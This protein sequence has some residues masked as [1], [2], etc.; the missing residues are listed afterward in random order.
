[1]R[2]GKRLLL[3]ICV[4]ALIPVR[5]AAAAPRSFS[6]FGV[7]SHPLWS[8]RGEADVERELDAMAAAGVRWNRFDV[9]WVSFEPRKGEFSSWWFARLDRVVKACLDRGIE[10]QFVIISTPGWA[11]DNRGWT[12]P[13]A[14]P[15]DISGFVRA[16]AFRYRGRVRYFE[17]W[18]EPDVATY[19][20]PSPD[21][22]AY[23]QM[24]KAAHAAAKEANPESVIIS[25]GLL[26][27]DLD[28]VQRMYDAGAKGYFDL[29]GLHLYPGHSGPYQPHDPYNI[30]NAR[31][32]FYGIP[33]LR[34]KLESNGDAGKNI[35]ISEFGWQT[36]LA[37][38]WPVSEATQALYIGQSYDRI[39][40]DFP[41]V[42]AACVYDI[43]ND[44][45]NLRNPEQ[46]LGLLRWN[47]APKPS[48]YAYG[49]ASARLWP[50]AK[51][52]ASPG[53]V[54]YPRRN[55]TLTARL[56]SAWGEA[57]TTIQRLPAGAETWEDVASTL[58]TSGTL[59]VSTIPPRNTL[60]RALVDGHEAARSV[61]ARVKPFGSVAVSPVYPRLRQL[62]RISGRMLVA[63]YV[64][65]GLYRKTAYGRWTRIRS[66]RTDATGRYSFTVR[67][68]RRG[69]F[70]YRVLLSLS[71][72]FEPAATRVVSV[73]A[74]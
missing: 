58:T 70:Y 15:S 40:E 49:L 26:G 62:V 10:P 27:N 21:A 28:F 64:T 63:P 5:S 71:S 42:E 17:V 6:P 36:S 47:L 43:R 68:F 25:G 52:T 18:N 55:T 31:W 7:A 38:Q 34:A 11:N 50:S 3:V 46:N 13:P 29:L 2:V 41:Y 44:G 30:V 72:S 22:T 9:G 61:R 4:L 14:R 20:R 65:V 35:W 60:Y 73:I 59:S 48:Y 19:W 33:G 23:V 67:H 1:M 69:R 54:A 66:Y 57:S 16:L 8:N 39:F 37:G 51:L 74:R 32:N 45:T 53:I 24:L 56:P 12:Y